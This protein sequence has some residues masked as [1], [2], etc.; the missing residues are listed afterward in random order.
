MATQIVRASPAAVYICN[1]W[2]PTLAFYQ[3]TKSNIDYE[4]KIE[5]DE[6]EGIVIRGNVE[7]PCEI[8]LLIN[9]EY[10]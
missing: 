9:Y 10:G 7:M 1:I 4:R 3:N 8:L 6:W 2:I 5:T